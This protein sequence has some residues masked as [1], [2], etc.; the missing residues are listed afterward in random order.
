MT[1]GKVSSA[2]E[3]VKEPL[4]NEGH[5]KESKKIPRRSGVKNECG[6]M[7]PSERRWRE[8]QKKSDGGG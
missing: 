1:S 2:H 3:P 7:V 6:D 4:E 8:A 5:K